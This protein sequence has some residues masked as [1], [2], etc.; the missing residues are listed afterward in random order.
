M[1]ANKIVIFCILA[2]LLVLFVPIPKGSYD[3]GGTREYESLTYKIVRWSRF[4]GE[5]DIYSK[6]RIYFFPEKN[7]SIDELWD[8]ECVNVKYTLKARIVEFNG[9]YVLVEPLADA[10]ESTS[11]DRISFSAPENIGAE[12]GDTVEIVYNGVVMESY[13]AQIIAESWKISE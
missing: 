1:K 12:V 13:P 9:D 4:I 3:D 6:T 11:A 10:W 5:D 8:K 2:V 7:K